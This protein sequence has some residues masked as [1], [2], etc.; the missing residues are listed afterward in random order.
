M[1]VAHVLVHTCVFTEPGSVC[2]QSCFVDDYADLYTSCTYI[3]QWVFNILDG[4]AEQDRVIF[5]DPDPETGFVLVP[6]FKWDQKELQNLYLLAIVRKRG[7]LSLREL[8]AEH[9][10]LL[11]NMLSKGQVGWEGGQSA[12]WKKP[13][14]YHQQKQETM[15]IKRGGAG[16]Q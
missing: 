6:D 5:S 9:L 3:L 1:L 11:R 12:V 7:I 16:A 13:F 15:G 10:P 2:I 8:G 14:T 4:K